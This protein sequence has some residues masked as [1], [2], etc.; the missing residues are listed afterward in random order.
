MPNITPNSSLELY[1]QP[2]ISSGS[3]TSF[4]EYAEPRT[5]D[6]LLY[7]RNVG[8]DIGTLTMERDAGTGRVTQYRIEPDSIGPT[9]NGPAEAF[10]I[11]NPDFN[12][13]SLRG[14]AVLRW[15]YRLGSTL[16]LVY[17]RSQIPA[18]DLNAFTPPATL[19]P[20]AFNHG[21]STDV[22][23]LKLSYWWGS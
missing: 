8:G 11:D 1:A 20:R 5:S 10:T 13:R 18:L 4:K 17:T 16:Y 12:I 3:Y 22:V 23:L 9:S 14:T 7:G 15:E 2:F 6:V 19:S 21:A